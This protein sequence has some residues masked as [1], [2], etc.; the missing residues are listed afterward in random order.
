MLPPA[1]PSCDVMALQPGGAERGLPQSLSS[2][3]LVRAAHVHKRQLRVMW[4]MAV[5]WSLRL[6]PEG[7]DRAGPVTAHTGFCRSNRSA[8]GVG[9]KWAEAPDPWDRFLQ[10]F[11]TSCR[12]WWQWRQGG[13]MW[14]SVRAGGGQLPPCVHLTF[15]ITHAETLGLTPDPGGTAGLRLFSFLSRLNHLIQHPS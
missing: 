1:E 15:S 6:F 11:Q 14:T 2:V 13:L 4:K 12:S 7:P 8:T 9:S 5:E 10:L 3:L